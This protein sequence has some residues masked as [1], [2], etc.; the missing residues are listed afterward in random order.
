V[1][2]IPIGVAEELF[3]VGPNDVRDNEDLLIDV[4]ADFRGNLE[5]VARFS[6]CFAHV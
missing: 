1:T 4:V 3:D 2:L 6:R 5:K